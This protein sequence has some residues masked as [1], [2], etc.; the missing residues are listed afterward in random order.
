MMIRVLIV[1]DEPLARENLRLRLRGEADVEIVGECDNGVQ[2]VEAIR[3]RDPDVVFL[4]IEMPGLDGFGV[5]SRLGVEQMPV[6]VF[7]TAYERYAVRAFEVHA[8]DYLLKPIVDERFAALLRRL[9]SHRRDGGAGE[10]QRR[11][12][13]FLQEWAADRPT[14]TL[15]PPRWVVRA[16]DRVFF[17]PE[18]TVEWVEAGADHI[19]LHVRGE[20]HP[21]RKSMAEAENRL[22][23]R[24]FVRIH[25][26][27]I[28]NLDFVQEMHPLF[29]GEY[30][31]VLR[32]G[33]R[34]KLSRRYRDRLREHLGDSI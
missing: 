21:V 10:L 2:A 20:V 32:D 12:S 24:R 23:P 30:E 27:T 29:R 1:D 26:S 4:D 31:V 28:V 7:V 14:R 33:T 19:R 15:A 5:V 11:L 16:S 6:V 18:E 17:I 9:R 13:T 34:L 22:D 3:E 8:L 25:R